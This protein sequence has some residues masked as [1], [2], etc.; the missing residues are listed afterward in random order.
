MISREEIELL[1]KTQRESYNDCIKH[2]LTTFN[3]RF[4]KI[5][6]ELGDSRAENFQLKSANE[7]QHNRITILSAKLHDIDQG[8]N[9]QDL[10]HIV[11]KLNYLED[12]SRRNNLRFEGVE[13]QEEENWEQTAEKIRKIAQNNLGIPT[14]VTIE[15]AHR[16]G[17]RK[18]NRPRTIIAKFLHF[19]EKQDILRKSYKLKGTNI[20]VN[21]D[22]C[23]ASQ[24]KRREQ[25]PLLRDA[26]RD[27]KLAYF[28]HTK[29]IIRNKPVGEIAHQQ[30]ISSNFT[31]VLARNS[32]P[33]P[34]PTHQTPATDVPLPPSPPLTRKSQAAKGAQ[35]PAQSVK[36]RLQ[37]KAK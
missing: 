22:L 35:Q 17:E 37:S 28:V 8:F 30:P 34:P 11:G 1:L 23:E 29:L 24:E 7:E 9:K 12:Q 14:G 36:N 25:L 16:I 19:G 10:D 32:H 26:K 6:K 20:F 2:V 3:D 27:G 4:L 18:Y 33:Q 21:E 31:P 13:E 15:R 5:E